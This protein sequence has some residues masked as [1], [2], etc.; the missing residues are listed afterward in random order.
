M[1]P[2][3]GKYCQHYTFTDLRRYYMGYDSITNL[4]SCPFEGCGELMSDTD[5]I[6][7]KEVS[8]IM[9]Y[10]KFKCDDC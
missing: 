7:L 5:I 3:R 6:Y 4:Y 10:V 8:I 1:D 2:A 9:D